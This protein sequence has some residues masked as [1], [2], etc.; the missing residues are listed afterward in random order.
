MGALTASFLFRAEN[1]W[2]NI[3]E[4]EY[5]RLSQNL[6]WRMLAKEIPSQSSK[7][8][9]L[10]I[11]STMQIEDVGV[12]GGN[13][14]FDDLAQVL[15]TFENRTRAAGLKLHRNQF[16][17]ADGNGVALGA[18]WASDSGAYSAYWPQKMVIQALV[19]RGEDTNFPGFDKKPLF[20]TDHPYNPFR[21]ELGTYSNL[22]A[23]ANA[24]PID[25]S[26]TVDVAFDN[27]AALIGTKIRALKMPNGVDPRFLGP[28]GFRLVVP[29]ALAPRAAVLTSAKFIAQAAATG[30]GS[31]DV[32]KLVSSYGWKE[33][34]VADELAPLPTDDST[35]ITKKNQ[36]YYV[37]V[38]QMESS[39]LGA[40]VYVNRE[41]FKVTYFTGQGGGTGVDAVL[42][43]AREL[44]WHVQGR[45]VC[46]P[47]FPYLI[48]KSR[49]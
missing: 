40:L 28:T 36:T 43:R 18:K 17:D 46:G 25:S 9:I 48:F 24:F 3:Q 27:L 19:D 44:E 38:E 8:I 22:F 1:N 5:A 13:I 33:P 14:P 45:N 30:G 4:N 32:E 16:E 11:L 49:P 6:Y 2:R 7:E 15:T 39:Q 12:Q 29:P 42:D 37:A 21:T 41:P 35:T 31:T 20:A 26:V 23:G 10:W 34:I 47:G